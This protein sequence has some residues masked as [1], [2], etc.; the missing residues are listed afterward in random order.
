M[1]PAVAGGVRR[2]RV[3]RQRRWIRLRD[4]RGHG[5]SGLNIPDGQR[6]PRVTGDRERHGV[7]RELG[8]VLLRARRGDR[9]GALALQDRRRRGDSQ[10]DRQSGLGGRG[11]R[12]RV[13]G[14][15]DSKLYELDAATGRQDWLIDNH[16]SWVIGSPAVKD[17]VIYFTTSDSGMFTRRTRRLAQSSSRCRSSGRCSRRRRLPD[18]C[19]IGSHEGKPLAIDRV[20]RKSAWVFQ[21]DALRRNG[22]A[23]TTPDGKPDY[24]PEM[25]TPFYDDMVAGVQKMFTVGAM[26]SSPVD[27]RRHGHRGQCRRISVRADLIDVPAGAAGRGD[28]A[29]SLVLK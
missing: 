6:R 27:R 29:R 24:A 14:C 26:L 9:Q 1:F 17:G 12:R 25:P 20:A 4:R 15:R 22:P 5:R 13:F 8:H 18:R 28:H 21:T 11:R 19:Y 3:F 16:G 23:L 7:H 2:P 10:P